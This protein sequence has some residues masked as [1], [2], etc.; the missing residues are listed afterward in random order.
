MHSILNLFRGLI[1]IGLLG[2]L[3]RESV[4]PG[5]KDYGREVWKDSTQR[6]GLRMTE[7]LRN[8]WRS[9]WLRIKN[10]R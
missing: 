10:R 3:G 6:L 2:L 4:Q 9:R 1:R 5:A 7:R 8:A